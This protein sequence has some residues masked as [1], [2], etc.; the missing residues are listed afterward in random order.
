MENPVDMTMDYRGFDGLETIFV[1]D[2]N[3]ID[4]DIYTYD[5]KEFDFENDIIEPVKKSKKVGKKNH[6]IIVAEGVDMLR[7]LASASK[8]NG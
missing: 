7:T 3:E 8:V 1:D 4:I 2:E 5:S 6:I